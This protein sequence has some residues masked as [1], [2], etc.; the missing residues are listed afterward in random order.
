MADKLTIFGLDYNNIVGIKA[1]DKNGNEL[2]YTRYP[3]PIPAGEVEDEN[4]VKF[5]D[6]DGTLLH[7]YSVTDFLALST[8]PANP[9]HSGLVA[10]GWNWTLT[11]AKAYV[12]A[13]GAL[14]IGQQYVT[15]S[16]RTEI[17]I[18]LG[19]KALSP[20]LS[21]A[22]NG[23][24]V[25][26]WGDGSSSTV[27]GTSLTT[28]KTTQHIYASPGS[29]TISI[30]L[31]SGSYALLSRTLYGAILNNNDTS[32]VYSSRNAV[33][34][35]AITAVRLGTSV[36]LGSYAF[37]YCYN[38]RYV[39]FSTGVNSLGEYSFRGCYNIQA[40]VLPAGSYN[41]GNYAFED[42]GLRCVSFGNGITGFGPYA[43][44]DSHL[45]ILTI[46]PTVTS[47]GSDAF[48]N[49]EELKYAIIPSGVTLVNSR[50]FQNC[51]SLASVSLPSGTA[52]GSGA[53]GSCCHLSSV[54]LPADISSISAN[55]F[56][57]CV[58][59][60]SINIPSCVTSIGAS[61]FSYCYSLQSITVNAVTPPT[62]DSTSFPSYI[63]GM[64]KIYVPSAS[65]DA[66]K[67][68]TNWA[69]FAS[70]MEGF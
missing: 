45:R 70:C 56:T 8:M 4:P 35:S 2:T 16:G 59:L 43:F 24:C 38:L 6:Y 69:T 32:S 10:Q 67:A 17:D 58:T 5:I 28:V 50:A 13:Y 26:Y 41:V 66:Y 25:I 36:V 22:P 68:A 62:L 23:T 7:S 61:A 19:A 3:I 37:Q 52:Y 42:T 20:L 60:R 57:S 53:F 21:I 40:V 44:S 51:R 48:L 27:T 54:S 15:A 47:I 11:D 1:H 65:L 18:T 64:F 39:T 29:Y 46:P 49:N 30:H 55:A 34:S 31:S 63:I 14:I 9:S 12:N 33:Y